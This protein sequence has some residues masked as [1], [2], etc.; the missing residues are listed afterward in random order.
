MTE[1]EIDR[2]YRSVL[3]PFPE[4]VPLNLA[5]LEEEACDGFT[6]SL[7]AWNNDATERVR[8][9]LLR[10]ASGSAKALAMMAFHGHGAWELGKKSTAGL[11]MGGGW[12]RGRI[13]SAVPRSRPRTD[14]GNA[15]GSL[16]LAGRKTGS[17]TRRLGGS[18]H[19]GAAGDADALPGEKVCLIRGQEGGGP[20]HI[21]RLRDPAKGRDGLVLTDQLLAIGLGRRALWLEA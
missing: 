16:R 21:L 3:G 8:G 4:R 9:Y 17:L 1:K 5:F 11:G 13:P 6:R 2:L 7:I 20:S 19:P 15:P 12:R 18:G 14:P 10:P